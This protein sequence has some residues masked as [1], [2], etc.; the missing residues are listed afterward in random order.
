M[1]FAQAR[2]LRYR[3]AERAHGAA[4]AL[5]RE[6]A[7]LVRR[8]RESL[9]ESGKAVCVREW[10]LAGN[11]GREQ[12]A[13]PEVLAALLGGVRD[14]AVDDADVTDDALPLR[15]RKASV[16]ASEGRRVHVVEPKNMR[17]RGL[18]DRLLDSEAEHKAIVD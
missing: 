14:E 8:V 6:S 9:D 13:E 1:R 3:V 7:E 4:A 18:V 2:N 12:E 17:E 11:V 16:E 10:G 5:G 15:E